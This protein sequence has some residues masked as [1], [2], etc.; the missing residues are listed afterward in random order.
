M[1]E[2]TENILNLPPCKILGIHELFSGKNTL[3]TARILADVFVTRFGEHWG[4]KEDILK[5]LLP[6]G[7][8]NTWANLDK[9]I[10][11]FCKQFYPNHE[12]H[13]EKIKFLDEA[14]FIIQNLPQKQ[15]YKPTE[16][17]QDYKTPQETAHHFVTCSL[18]WRA[19]LRQPL[20]KKTPLCHIHDL[21]STNPTY[22]RRTRIKGQVELRKLQ[23]LKSLPGLMGLRHDNK[24]DLDRYVQEL[25]LNPA[26]PLPYLTSYLH[27]LKQ[28]P[29]NLPLQTGKDV[30]QALEHPIYPKLP[31]HIQEAWN[32]YLDDRGKHFHLNYIKI[33]TAE[34]WLE[35]DAK[36][37]HGGKRR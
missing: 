13:T 30:L 22:R 8:A 24:T 25:C 7:R 3:E 11:I 37:Q 14:R 36:H 21:P 27:S 12:E 35:I 20:E 6:K 1:S 16:N 33:L 17:K 29:L 9:H 4:T 32:Y 28:P 10:N 5:H 26:C 18:C 2:P 15:D 19:V 31:P 23:L 34:A